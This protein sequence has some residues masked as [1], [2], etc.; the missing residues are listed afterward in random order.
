[1]IRAGELIH[2]VTIERFTATGTN[3]VGETE[4]EWDVT[5]TTR[6]SIEPLAGQEL[7]ESLKLGESV[8]AQVRMRY[9]SETNGVAAKDR[10]IWGTKVLEIFSVVNVGNANKELLLQ[11]IDKGET[12]P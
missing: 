2:S 1:M 10:L 3:T 9:G 6:A 11:V 12:S 4:K 7:I 8:T 5:G